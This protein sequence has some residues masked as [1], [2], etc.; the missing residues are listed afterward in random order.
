MTATPSTN[1]GGISTDAVWRGR[2]RKW[3][4]LTE[5]VPLDCQASRALVALLQIPQRRDRA[6]AD[7][8]WDEAWSWNG[9]LSSLGGGFGNPAASTA[10][11]VAQSVP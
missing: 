4:D 3:R 9:V 8:V 7:P 2:C 11:L 10:T 5:R 6:V 1:W